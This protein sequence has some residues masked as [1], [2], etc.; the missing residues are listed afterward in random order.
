MFTAAVMFSTLIT[1]KNVIIL[2]LK[3]D[4]KFNKNL[5]SLKV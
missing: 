3:G 1:Y 5:I 2:P 4:I